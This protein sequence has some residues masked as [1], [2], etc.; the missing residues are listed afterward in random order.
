MPAGHRSA[1]AGA[2]QDQWLHAVARLSL[3]QA[4]TR[5]W[6]LAEAARGC[7]EVGIPGIGL[8]RDAV[9]EV[10]AAGAARLVRAA[11]L[12]VTSLC[13]GGF[14]TA[15]DAAGRRAALADN[16]AAIEEA[17]ETGAPV[18]VMVCGGLPPGSQDLA[19]AR[20]MVEDGIAELAPHAARCG[21][22]LAIEPMHPMFCADRSVIS[23]VGQALAIA[24]Q[25]PAAQAGIMIDTYHVWWDPQVEA[26]IAQAGPY[27]A[28]FQISDWVVP[29]TGDVLLA[30]GHVGDGCIDFR[31]LDG[32]VRA[33]GYQGWTE[34]EIFSR[35]VW[36]APGRQTVRTVVDRYLR[37]VAQG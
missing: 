28:G 34:V 16:R 33:A 23:T 6:T 14:L 19:G 8:W 27:I 5:R 13:R 1:E 15:G 30:R 3:N 29:I 25:F 37:H 7:A 4:T 11:G 17:A 32:A 20:R 35:R 9:E 21:V 36:D 12:T 18:L 22:R 10:G 2:G 26:A 24:A 31:R